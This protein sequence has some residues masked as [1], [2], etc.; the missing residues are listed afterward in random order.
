MNCDN[1]DSGLD[2][3]VNPEVLITSL[4]DFIPYTKYLKNAS[5]VNEGNIYRARET[6]V[7]TAVFDVDDWEILF[8]A[9]ITVQ[10]ISQVEDDL[11]PTLGGN[12]IVPTNVT[13]DASVDYDSKDIIR[14]D[15]TNSD[16]VSGLTASEDSIVLSI[17]DPDTEDG[18]FS[19]SGINIWQEEVSLEGLYVTAQAEYYSVYAPSVSFNSDYFIVRGAEEVRINHV[20][21]PSGVPDNDG[22]VWYVDSDGSGY[23]SSS[24]SQLHADT[25]KLGGADE[26][27][28]STL[29]GA[30]T[31]TH[32][33]IDQHIDTTDIHV[34]ANTLALI[35]GVP[36]ASID[37]EYYVRRNAGW[38]AIPTLGGIQEVQEDTSPQLGGN[39]DLNGN[40]IQGALSSAD[41]FV[42]EVD[43]A[44]TGATSKT[45]WLV[46]SNTTKA[47]SQLAAEV[48]GVTNTKADI[49]IVS[50]SADA[51]GTKTSNSQVLLNADEIILAAAQQLILNGVTFPASPTGSSGK[52]YLVWDNQG[53]SPSW[54]TAD[55]SEPIDILA[56][57]GT[58]Y[59]SGSYPLPQ[60]KTFADFKRIEMYAAQD[61][62]SVKTAGLVGVAFEEIL[63][64]HSSDIEIV[65]QSGASDLARMTATSTTTFTI[66]RTGTDGVWLIKGWLK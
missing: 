11:A 15:S 37:N 60:S 13:I 47:S 6:F 12:L 10:G 41:F 27:P 49:S 20:T 48:T 23:W 7:A 24:L 28:H 66:S 55:I 18:E 40:T 19:T 44:F 25:H 63:A 64:I 46:S 29:A 39:L 62:G 52:H 31:Y 50:G 61:T 17:Y 33:L 21:Y 38:A 51:T 14:F 2:L 54:E 42:N 3:P 1:P 5:T 43:H 56:Y 26:L 59:T 65:A 36:E 30:G 8:L 53:T 58:A 22:Q 35:G 34:G 57:T 4:P 45:N 16:L 32:A 9:G